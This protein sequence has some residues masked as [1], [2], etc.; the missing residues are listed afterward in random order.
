MDVLV[1]K[2]LLSEEFKDTTP[3]LV[4]DDP[5]GIG[6]NPAYFDLGLPTIALQSLPPTKSLMGRS[7]A[8]VVVFNVGVGSA[9]FTDHE[10][11]RNTLEHICRGELGY[12]TYLDM[13]TTADIEGST[14]T[15]ATSYDNYVKCL[16][17]EDLAGIIIKE[18]V[19]LSTDFFIRVRNARK[20]VAHLHSYGF[21]GEL[22]EPLYVHEEMA[23]R[24]QVPPEYPVADNISRYIVRLSCDTKEHAR[25]AAAIAEVESG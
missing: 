23:S 22:M 10:D 19:G 5:L 13:P 18:D 6:H 3:I 7:E 8:S 9:L 17:K 2:E 24:W 15:L 14:H 1:L 12:Y 25:V 16:H 4:L 11:L 20:V 21:V